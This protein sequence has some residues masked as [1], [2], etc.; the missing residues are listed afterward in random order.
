MAVASSLRENRSGRIHHALEVLGLVVGR[1]DQPGL[2]GHGSAYPSRACACGVRVRCAARTTYAGNVAERELTNSAI[3]D[4][5]EELGDLYELDGA[6]VHRVLAY[7]TAA[8]RVREAPVSVAALARAGRASELP[9]IG[10]TLQ[11]K[12]LALLDTG[13][14]PATEK[15]R[16]HTPSGPR[17]QARA[18]AAR[19]ARHR[20]PPGAARG[21]TRTATA[22][23]AGV[24]AQVRAGRARGAAGGNGR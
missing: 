6:I 1:K 7:R 11:E 16:D 21:G 12:I 20:L 13:T 19:R 18:A 10:S 5:L 2:A 24:W 8:K 17:A 15:L 22:L 9:G 23:G 14:I 4:A 3:A